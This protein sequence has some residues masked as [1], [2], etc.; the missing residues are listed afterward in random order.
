MTSV[1]HFCAQ[2]KS[3]GRRVTPQR[4]AIIQAL[5]ENHS[6]PT[7]DQVLTRVRSVMPDLSPATVY[8]TL[9]E[10]VD[11]GVLQELDLG[12]GERHY[13]FTGEDHAH[14][15]CLKCGR[16]ED[17]PY[18]HEAVELSPED[19]QGFQV[20]DHIVIFRGFCPACT[21]EENGQSG[22]P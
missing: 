4:R 2:L 7:A 21:P 10:L 11:I 20:I 19:A 9:H 12:L 6:H 16:I 14:L 15:V 13:D 22:A 3:R 1:D 5:L 8:N 17:A 18:D